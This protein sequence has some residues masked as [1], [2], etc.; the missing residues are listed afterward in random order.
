MA[1][2]QERRN[3]SPCHPGAMLALDSYTQPLNGREA[4]NYFVLSHC[5]FLA[6]VSGDKFI[7]S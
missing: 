3:P 5:Y 4:N 1:E 6:L 2:Q 7:S